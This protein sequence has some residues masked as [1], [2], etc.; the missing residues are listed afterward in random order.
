[1]VVTSHFT[2]GEVGA[3]REVVRRVLHDRQREI[4]ERAELLTSELVTNVFVHGS[5]GAVLTIDDQPNRIRVEVS[6]PDAFIDLRPIDSTPLD[7]HGRGLAIVAA[8]AS[9]WGVEPR[10]LGKAVWFELW[11]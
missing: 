3:A 8:L 7:L 5:D 9:S 1:M 10:L 6:D 4:V 2:R 11:S